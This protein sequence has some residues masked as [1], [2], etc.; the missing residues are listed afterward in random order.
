MYCI[1]DVNMQS[2]NVQLSETVSPVRNVY[3]LRQ[4]HLLVVTSR[5]SKTGSRIKEAKNTWLLNKIK[6]S[7]CKIYW[8]EKLDFIRI[9]NYHPWSLFINLNSIGSNSKSVFHRCLFIAISFF[10]LHKLSSKAATV[11]LWSLLS[12][13]IILLL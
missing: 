1:Q 7:F 13:Y 3:I 9:A 11:F 5:P 4:R 12:R 10:L 2:T 8:F 6:H